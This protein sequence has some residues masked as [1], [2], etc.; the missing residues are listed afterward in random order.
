MSEA[1][2]VGDDNFIKKLADLD[3]LKET[4]DNVEQMS[5]TVDPQGNILGDTSHMDP[6]ILAQLQ[7]PAAQ[8]S[9][10]EQYR[11]SRY[12]EEP[13]KPIRWLNERE[14][15]RLFAD[16]RPPNMT[17]REWRHKCRIAF[18]KTTKAVLKVKRSMD[19]G[20]QSNQ[21]SAG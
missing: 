20:G 17:P 1:I 7:T 6:H 21:P 16:R 9:M 4:V 2:I 10:R 19:N 13:P 12:A 5:I 3:K 8:K 14:D 18:R 11:A 15:R